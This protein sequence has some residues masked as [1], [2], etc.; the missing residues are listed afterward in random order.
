MNACVVCGEAAHWS[1]E[2]VHLCRL[3][4]TVV[5][6]EMWDLI[7]PRVIDRPNAVVYY[8]QIY[9]HAFMRAEIYGIPDA[10]KQT[11]VKIGTTV[12][13][14]RRLREL[15]GRLLV[16]EPGHYYKEHKRL[17][18]F[19]EQ[20]L[21]TSEIFLIDDRIR[22][23]VATLRGMDHWRNHGERELAEVGQATGLIAV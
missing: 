2:D 10:R 13:L 12:N 4:F 16:T 7:P 3:H 18:E 22:A 15:D 17:A 14:G 21:G 1:A 19:T 5:K 23:H 11:Y 9:E 8:A 20:R 6:G